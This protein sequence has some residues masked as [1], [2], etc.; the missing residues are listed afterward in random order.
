MAGQPSDQLWRGTKAQSIQSL[1]PQMAPDLPAAPMTPLF[2]CG[3][4]RVVY[5]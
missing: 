1:S 4:L 3:M 5:L 2:A